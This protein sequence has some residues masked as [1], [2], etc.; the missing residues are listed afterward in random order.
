M[1]G[2][3]GGTTKTGLKGPS[4]SL[5][6]IQWA[7]GYLFFPVEHT[8]RVSILKSRVDETKLLYEVSRFVLVVGVGGVFANIY[9]M[10]Q[11]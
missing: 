7:S 4:P 9:N 6:K 8:R 11:S 1:H 5:P 2:R 3:Q 10:L